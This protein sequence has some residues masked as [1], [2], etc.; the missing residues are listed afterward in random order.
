MGS[1]LHHG[2][3]FLLANLFHG[4]VQATHLLKSNTLTW[5]IKAQGEFIDDQLNEWRLHDST[6][7]TLPFI[8]TTPGDSVD[9]D[10]PARDLLINDYFMCYITPALRLSGFVQESWH[11]GDS[12][13]R[14]TARR[15]PAF[16]VWTLYRELIGNNRR[17]RQL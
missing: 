17:L 14:F 6:Y 4:E 9:L 15:R 10:N 5:G 8:P 11:F 13:H 7:Y 1:D 16:F 2:R 3:N 12:S